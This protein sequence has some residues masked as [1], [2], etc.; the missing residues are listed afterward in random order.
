[1]KRF[2]A[3]AIL[4]STGC[5][6]VN[7]GP[8]DRVPVS[9]DPAG[10]E[11]AVEC[12]RASRGPFTTPV[13]L[14]LSPKADDCRIHL[15]KAGYHAQTIEFQSYPRQ[16]VWWNLLPSALGVLSLVAQ[17]DE[18]SGLEAAGGAILSGVGFAIDGRNGSMW[19][20]EP[21][22]VDVKLQRTSDSSSAPQPLHFLNIPPSTDEPIRPR[23]SMMLPSLLPSRML[24]RP[25]APGVSF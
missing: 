12:G 21:K 16:S 13:V 25:P 10:A 15:T 11:V 9:T 3:I 19:T 6:T 17:A 22:G 14:V 23:S 20:L 5:A 24:A 4:I 7:H 1:M 8:I 2:A 18:A